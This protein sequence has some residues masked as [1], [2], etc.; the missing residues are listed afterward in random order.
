MIDTLRQSASHIKS[1]IDLIV[2]DPH[3]GIIKI[4]VGQNLLILDAVSALHFDWCK[5][6]PVLKFF[7]L[8]PVVNKKK[9]YFLKLGSILQFPSKS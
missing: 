8:F 6:T 7:H 1:S 9:K 5:Q 3:L 2:S 4:A